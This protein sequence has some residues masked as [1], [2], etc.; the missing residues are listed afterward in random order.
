MEVVYLSTAISHFLNCFISQAVSQP[1]INDEL[2][3]NSKRKGKKNKNGRGGQLDTKSERQNFDW[4]SLTPKSL[5]ASLRAEMDSYYGWTPGKDVDSIESL[6]NKYS[7]QKIA[8][9]RI[10]S[11]RTGIQ[12]L[13]REYNFEHKSRPTFG[14]D[15]ILNMFP[16]VKH[17]SPRATD[18]YNYYQ[19]GQRKIQEGNLREGYEYITEALNLFNNVYGPL[20]SDIVQC[21]R[22]L[23]RINYVLSDY[24][25][26]CSFQQKAVLMSEKVNGIDHPHTITE[27]VSY[28]PYLV[29]FF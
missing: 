11:I 10:F 14:E 2:N 25:E 20:H 16:I 27:Y 13:L 21:L 15:D 17:I 26:A 29:P 4:L 5:W 23:A 7:I 1:L 3:K 8:L 18:A 12:V 6:L 28:S 22:L 24:N 9:L 19:S